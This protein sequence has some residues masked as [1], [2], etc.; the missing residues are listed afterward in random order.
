[1]DIYNRNNGDAMIIISETLGNI[2]QH[3]EWQDKIRGTSPDYLILSPA[4]LEEECHQKSTHDGLRLAVFMPPNSMLVDGDILIW[5]EETKNSVIVKVISHDIM[6]I[7]LQR[8]LCAN[9]DAII[10]YAFKLGLILG[11]HKLHAIIKNNLV[12]VPITIAT[13]TLDAMFKENSFHSLSYWYV[14]GADIASL[15][16]PIEIDLLFDGIFPSSHV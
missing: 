16:T 10:H 7:N 2:N 14:N 8:L 11:Q 9:S 13:S 12:Y 15:L 1:M 4:Q 3:K 5:D 6:V